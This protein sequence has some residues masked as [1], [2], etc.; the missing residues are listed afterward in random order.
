[1]PRLILLRLLVIIVVT[2]MVGRLYQLQLVDQE[3]Q[4]FGSNPDV[5]TRR[6]L[7]VLPRRGEIY[8]ADGVTLVAESLPI[9]N[10][11]VVPGR[12][13]NATTDPER[14]ADVLTRLSL[15]AGLSA[16]LRLDPSVSIATHPALYARLQQLDPVLEWNT[17][18]PSTLIVAPEG[19]LEILDLVRAYAPLLELA[20]PI[21]AMIVQQ[22]VRGY[23]YVLVKE[24]ISPDLAMAIR[25]NANY[26]PG[27]EVTEGYRRSYPQS[28]VMQS[29]SHTLGYVGRITECELMLENPSTSWLTSLVDV[30]S[31]AG[32]CGLI[33]KQID[34]TS[35]GQLPYQLDD[36]IGK[37]GLEGAYEHDLRGRIGID[38]LLVDAL[39]RPVGPLQQVRPVLNGNNLVMTLDLAFQAEVEQIMRRWI[40][41]GERRRVTAPEPYKQA[42]DPIIAGSAVVIDPRDG[43]I[44]AMVSLPTYDN[45]VWVT[46]DRQAELQALLTRSD[47]EELAELLRLAPLTNRAIA[48]QYPPGSTLKQFVG[49]IALQ[50]GVITPETRLRDPGLLQLIERSGALF[51]LPNSV[52]NRDNG[53]LTVI[54]AMRLSSNVFFASIAGGNDQA[55]NLRASDLR[56]NGLQIDRLVEGLEWFQL[57]RRTG[58]D[59][60]GEASGLVPTRTW[61][62]QAKREVWT[63]GDTYNTAIG[64]GDMQ[65][66]PLQLAVAAGA[67]AIDGTI[68]RPHIVSRIVDT[69]GNL[70]REITPEVLQRVPIEPDYLSVMREGM[71][72]SIINGLGVAARPECSGLVIAGKT[73]TAEFGPLIQRTDGRLIRQSHAWFVGFAPYDNPEVVVAVLI[74]G[75]GDLSDG[76]STMAVPATTQ[77]MQAY[78][79]ASRPE[80]APMSCPVLPVEPTEPGLDTVGHTP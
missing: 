64:Q 51:E 26:L 9:Y 54:D 59:L 77:I 6:T 66:T 71:L 57:G 76:S 25:E 1:M 62:V 3:S 44:L 30:V 46:P 37:E 45:N 23:Q 16:T 49:A 34:P 36:R 35:I 11:S 15:V 61:K 20:N 40:A 19:I 80:D 38:T 74:E 13:P 33:P 67:V 43:R 79:G 78:F 70:V 5:I 32:R 73:G 52:R 55:S 68:Y 50:A 47:P 8:A 2:I 24:D 75:V 31:R 63:T 12:L 42:Y 17:A 7:T 29:L 53:E 39:Q 56:V 27:T 72:E 41:E 21:E 28:E 4:R 65:V 69:N 58:V 48:G 22:N 18:E 60:V 14:R 10:L